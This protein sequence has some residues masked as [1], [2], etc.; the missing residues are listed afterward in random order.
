VFGGLKREVKN[1]SGTAIAIA[2]ETSGGS[3]RFNTVMLALGS[4]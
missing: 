2:M 1:T 4:P 3:V